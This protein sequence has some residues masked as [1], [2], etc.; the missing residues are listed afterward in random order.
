MSYAQDETF[1]ETLPEFLAWEERQEERYEFIGGKIFAMVGASL[2]HN[3]IIQNL[4]HAL[5]PVLKKPPCRVFSEGVKLTI[6]NDSFYPD[7]L[8]NC[9]PVSVQDRWVT[10]AVLL[11]EVLSPSTEHHDRGTKLHRYTTL[12]SLRHYLIISQEQQIIEHYSRTRE[13]PFWRFALLGPTESARL[14]ALDLDVAVA[15]IYEGA[16]VPA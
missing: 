6:G 10:D 15:A 4:C 3:I 5:R 9:S 2:A 14:A 8:V 16:E 7:A 11:A 13:D 1:F 12:P